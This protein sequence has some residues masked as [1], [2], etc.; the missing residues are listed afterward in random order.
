MQ[1]TQKLVSCVAPLGNVP[2]LLAG[3]KDGTIAVWDVRN[4]KIALT[5][6]GTTTAAENDSTAM[7][8]PYMIKIPVS[9]ACGQQQDFSSSGHDSCLAPAVSS[10]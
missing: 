2:V 6:A 1:G 4:N 5:L 8:R 3:G 10:G 9:H 7:V